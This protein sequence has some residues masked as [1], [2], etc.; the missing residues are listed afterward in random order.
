MHFG[1]ILVS[2]FFLAS[3]VLTLGT[4]EHLVCQALPAYSST[5]NLN[6]E[7][8]KRWIGLSPPAAYPSTVGHEANEGSLQPRH[9]VYAIDYYSCVVHGYLSLLGALY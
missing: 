8:Y 9:H 7:D 3:H 5:L 2:N 4:G 1:A 6:M